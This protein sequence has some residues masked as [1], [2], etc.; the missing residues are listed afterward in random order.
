[1]KHSSCWAGLTLAAFI[2]GGVTGCSAPATTAD[3]KTEDEYI[4]VK[5]TG[6]NIP[7]KIKKSDIAAGKLPK[8][9]DMQLMDKDALQRQMVPGKA[10]GG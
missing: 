9:V 10:P 1:M 4:Y 5:V 6:S 8:D 2:I 7:K 3:K